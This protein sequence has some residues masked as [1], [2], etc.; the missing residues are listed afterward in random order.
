MSTAFFVD[1]GDLSSCRAVR[2]PVT[3]ETARRLACDSGMVRVARGAEDGSVR[4]VGRKTRTVPPAVRRALD[5]RDRGC[6]FPGCGLRFTDVHHIRHWADGGETS[7][8]NL[9]LLCRR[10]H[11]K[12]H[13]DGHR[14]CLDRKG[15]VV[16]FTPRGKAM[17]EVPARGATSG[18][19]D[20]SARE[21][22]GMPARAPTAGL[23]TGHATRSR[24]VDRNAWSQAPR[25][26]RDAD[27]P[28]HIEDAAVEAVAAGRASD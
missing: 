28:W 19:A 25:W 27:I 21:S 13:E 2:R 23:A 24:G 18:A 10:H 3:A 5:T 17:F 16:F 15:Q 9:V 8:R 1:R 20:E 22:A 7:L 12:V 14:V 4:S 6:R 26:K 11:R